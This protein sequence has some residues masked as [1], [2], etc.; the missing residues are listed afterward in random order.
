MPSLRF[1]WPGP[2]TS[3][4]QRPHRFLTEDFDGCLESCDVL[5][6]LLNLYPSVSSILRITGKQLEAC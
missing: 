1:F 2:E 4:Q 5:V 3:V 6:L